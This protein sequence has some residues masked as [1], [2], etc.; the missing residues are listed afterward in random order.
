MVL[1]MILPV[2]AHLLED[3]KVDVRHAASTALVSISNMMKPND[4]GQYV[5]TIILVCSMTLMVSVI[6]NT[7][8]ILAIS[9]RR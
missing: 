8:Y 2:V 7:N 5:L 1:D 9:S 4:L 6:C 3:D